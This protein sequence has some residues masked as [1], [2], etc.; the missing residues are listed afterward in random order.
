MT[1]IIHGLESG[2]RWEP[3]LPRWVRTVDQSILIA[4]AALFLIGLLLCIAASPPLAERLGREPFT[5]VYRH[6]VFGAG[7]L[8]LMFFLSLLT[9]VA[10]RRF[11]SVLFICALL[12]LFLLPFFGTDFGKGAVRW[13]SLGFGSIQ[14]SEFLKPGFIIVCAWL[15]AGS[16]QP[17]GPPGKSISLGLTV[18]IVATLAMQPDF[19]QS[20]LF[21]FGWCVLFFVAGAA[22]WPLAAIAGA[23][24]AGGYL[25]FQ[26]S[27]HFARRITAFMNGGGGPASQV[28]IAV[29]AIREGGLFGVGV[30]QGS[31]KWSLPD[32]HTDFI[33]A[34]AAEEYGFGLV[35]VIIGLFAFICIRSVKL[36]RGA[37]DPFVRLAG[38]G[39]TAMVSIQAFIHIAVS[40]NLLPAKGLTLPFIS[41]GGS[42]MMATGI[43]FGLL[44]AFIRAAKEDRNGESESWG[45]PRSHGHLRTA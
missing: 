14:P 40:A 18:V 27:E 30:G 6:A 7:S 43:T 21:I 20:S 23:T 1:D 31:V 39:L 38:T 29:S 37:A 16:M 22:I 10:A 15:I 34:V 45:G 32:A 36:L 8:A 28:D 41:Y 12:S 5:F 3:L 4:I 44:L 33:V 13:F 9:P 24:V 19:G 17:T 42:S 26:H 35:L 2:I 11:G 25:A